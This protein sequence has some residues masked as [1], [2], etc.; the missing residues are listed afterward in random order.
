VTDYSALRADA[1][2]LHPDLVRCDVTCT[3]TPN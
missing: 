1:A 3:D 2:V